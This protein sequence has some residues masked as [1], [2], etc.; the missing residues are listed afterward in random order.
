MQRDSFLRAYTFFQYDQA[1]RS[2]KIGNISKALES[3]RR[4]DPN[5]ITPYMAEYHELL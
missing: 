5:Q 3:I 1:L 2:A 4:V